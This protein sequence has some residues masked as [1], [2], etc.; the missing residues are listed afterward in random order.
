MFWPFVAATLLGIGLI[1]LGALS[2]WTSVL[3][4]ALKVL[5]LAAISILLLL[6]LVFCWRRYK[7]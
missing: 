1:K 4:L 3:V 2:V 5:I 7:R 6:G